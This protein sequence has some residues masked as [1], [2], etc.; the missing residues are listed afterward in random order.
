[1]VLAT[2]SIRQFPLHFPSIASPCAITFQLNSTS[3]TKNCIT[4]ADSWQTPSKVGHF[5]LI[6]GLVMDLHG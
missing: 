2:Y 4:V 1:M 5:N 3:E 6:K